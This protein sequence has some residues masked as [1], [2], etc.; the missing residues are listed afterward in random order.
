M[1]S[2]Y[3]DLPR[4]DGAL[5][6]ICCRPSIPGQIS[7]YMYGD[8][9]QLAWTSPCAVLTVLGQADFSPL[10]LAPVPYRAAPCF[11]WAAQG[12][13]CSSQGVC[14]GRCAA[15][16]RRRG[17]SG[18]LIV[19][20]GHGGFSAGDGF[21]HRRQPADTCLRMRA[22]RRNMHTK[23]EWLIGYPNNGGCCSLDAMPNVENEH[24]LA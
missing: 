13:C 10:I 7:S 17:S 1:G 12:V 6:L 9:E 24:L 5:D 15:L 18:G 2:L 4:R 3:F 8:H 11:R 23:E 16:L 19:F 20:G 22:L 21:L 14:C